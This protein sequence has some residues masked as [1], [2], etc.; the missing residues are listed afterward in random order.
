MSCRKRCGRSWALVPQRSPTGGLKSPL[1]PS[2]G[3]V[4]GAGE[5]L[6]AQAVEGR[7]LA[8]HGF[9][10]HPDGWQ[11]THLLIGLRWEVAVLPGACPAPSA[12]TREPCLGQQFAPGPAPSAWPPLLSPRCEGAS[13]GRLARPSRARGGTG[14]CGGRAGSAAPPPACAVTAVRRAARRLSAASSFVVTRLLSACPHCTRVRPKGLAVRETKGR[15]PWRLRAA[16][17]C[18]LRPRFQRGE[19]GRALS[20]LVQRPPA[21]PRRAL[22]YRRCGR[23][24]S[25]QRV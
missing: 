10:P 14:R 22:S 2:L 16:R 21:P 24:V 20:A 11:S 3:L 7:V 13:P 15:W 25:G 6:D 17:P 19:S 5:G 18:G 1:K 9:F 23:P 8:C 4:R 12:G